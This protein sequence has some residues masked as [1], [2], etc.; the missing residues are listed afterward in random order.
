LILAKDVKNYHNLNRINTT[1]IYV[2]DQNIILFLS[3]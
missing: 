2:E 1:P 3:R